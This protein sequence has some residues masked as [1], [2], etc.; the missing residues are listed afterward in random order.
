MCIHK[1]VV[2][3]FTKQFNSYNNQI[4]INI[5]ITITVSHLAVHPWLQQQQIYDCWVN[6]T[7]DDRVSLTGRDSWC[8]FSGLVPTPRRLVWSGG[9]LLRSI[10]GGRCLGRIRRIL[11][12]RST[13]VGRWRGKP[14]WNHRSIRSISFLV[15]QWSWFWWLME[16]GRWFPFAYDRQYL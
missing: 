10:C 8:C 15:E 9:W 16:R 14:R 11:A 7:N 5:I 4:G 6:K 12:W 13:S 2:V 3:M 1:D